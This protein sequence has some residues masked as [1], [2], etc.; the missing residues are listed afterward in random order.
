MK[1]IRAVFVFLVVLVAGLRKKRVAVQ[2]LMLRL[3]LNKGKQCIKG[4]TVV[5]T[6]LLFIGLLLTTESVLAFKPNEQGHLGITSDA[7]RSIERVVGGV[8][9]RFSPQAL[10][11]I[12]KAN[13]STDDLISGDFFRSEKHFD[14]E[15]FFAGTTRLLELKGYIISQITSFSPNGKNARIALGGVLHTI[16]DFYAHTNWVE[17][18]HTSIDTRLGRTTIPK[19]P[20]TTPTSP[21]N[22]PSTLLPGLTVLTS[23]YFVTPPYCGAPSGKTRHG[24]SGLCTNGLNKDEPGRP[25]YLQAR[26]LAVTASQDF[27]NQILDTPGVAGNDRAIRTLMGI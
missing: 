25:G 26:G 21:A 20:I 27:I 5:T 13:E 1:R 22:D 3:K 9:L 4:F 17:L 11:E 8:R 15:E 14:N 12:R 18:G 23:G 24:V 6:T 10:E 19:P 16:Q 2:K 7:V